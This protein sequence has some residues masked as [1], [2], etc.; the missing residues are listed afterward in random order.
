MTRNLFTPYL[1]VG[2]TG[3]IGSGK[4]TAA[5]R[6][7]KLGAAVFH[8]D[9]IARHALDPETDCYSRV[10][11][12]FGSSI[13][14]SNGAIDRKKL[15]QVI[16]ASQE[17][18]NILNAIIHPY[19]ISTLYSLADAALAKQQNGIAIFDVP[20]LFESGMDADM[21]V[22]IVVFCDEETRIRRIIERDDISRAQAI[23]RMLAQMPEQEKCLR[24]D[25]LLD[26]NGSERALQEQVDALYQTLL[27]KDKHA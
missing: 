5:K 20:L 9:E 23:S 13:L 11:A 8:A 6:F 19:V 26:N 27:I 10:A 21:D 4:T 14:L 25:Y 7:A 17:K 12:A 2:L 18:R 15:A 16:F 22:N 3:G 24:A 1:C